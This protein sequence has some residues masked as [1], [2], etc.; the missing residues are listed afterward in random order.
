[1]TL[2]KLPEDW[3]SALP[4][5]L[6]K[7]TSFEAGERLT[8]GTGLRLGAGTVTNFALENLGGVGGGMRDGV[9]VRAL[10]EVLLI[11]VAKMFDPGKGIFVGVV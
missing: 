5:F 1:M 6:L 9:L 7:L 4:D 11:G 2:P 10:L 3:D 8:A